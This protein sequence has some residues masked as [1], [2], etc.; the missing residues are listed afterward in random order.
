MSD[1]LSR[2]DLIGVVGPCLAGKTTLINNLKQF[3]YHCRHIAQE[4][5]FVP[6]MW[7]RIVD[8]PILIFLDVSYDVSMQRKKLNMNSREFDEQLARLDHAR[9]HADIYLQTDHLTPRKVLEKILSQ[10]EDREMKSDK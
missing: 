1:N 8:P 6:D 4:H 9:R 10:L 2:H 7:Q 5:S 3:G